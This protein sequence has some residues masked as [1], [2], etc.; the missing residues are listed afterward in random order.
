MT[1]ETETGISRSEDPLI[2]A[3]LITVAQ[4][5]CTAMCASEVVISGLDSRGFRGLAGTGEAPRAS[6]G[7]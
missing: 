5:V 6:A 1:S 4:E 2:L 7:V 3:V